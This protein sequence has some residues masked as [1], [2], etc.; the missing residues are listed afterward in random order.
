ASGTSGTYVYSFY[1]YKNG[2]Q[3]PASRQRTKVY[4]SSGDIQVVSLVS[5]VTLAPGDYVEVWTED[6]ESSVDINVQN[7]T[8][9][10]K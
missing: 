10:I 9:S 1:I 2:V 4:S 3:I 7:M 6:N 5:T 8:L